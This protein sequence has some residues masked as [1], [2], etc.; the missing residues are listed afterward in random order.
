MAK[1]SINQ[2]QFT[3]D[4]GIMIAQSTV[5]KVARLTGVTLSLASAFYALQTTGDKYV[6]TLR[7]N[8]LRFG[9]FI[10]TI[11]QMEKAQERL[12][13]GQTS[14][15]VDDQLKGLNQ[16]AAVGINVRKDFDFINK[17]AHATGK[18][19]SEFSSAI[20][21]AV[22]GNMQSLV[23]MGL[24]TQRATR[25]FDKYTAN[26]VMRQQA[27]LNFVK[28]HKGLNDLI[29]NDFENIQDQIVRIKATW[30]G[31][32]KGVVGK[33]NDPESLYGMVNKSLKSIAQKFSQSYKDLKQ[34]GKG[35]G[36]VMGWTVRQIGRTIEWLG[37]QG[38][39][40]INFLLGSSETFVERMRTL[41]V[42]LEF[43]RLKVRD[44]FD[45]YGN[46]IK[47]I[48]KWLLIFKGLKTVF[49]ISKAAIASAYAYN[50]ALF[51]RLGFFT[52]IKRVQKSIGGISWWKAF[53]LSV[54]PRWLRRTLTWFSRFFSVT[55]PK[56]LPKTL[57]LFK[58]IGSFIGGGL[59]S[60]AGKLIGKF[61]GAVGIWTT[62]YETLQWI[63]RKVFGI[64]NSFGTMMKNLKTSW[65]SL[66]NNF[67]SFY[68]DFR[69]QW[70]SFSDWW[71]EHVTEPI[72]KRW[73]DAG[74]SDWFTNMKNNFKDLIDTVKGWLEPIFK[75][76]RS[77]MNWFDERV[78]TF[79]S[80]QGQK[81]IQQNNFRNQQAL[82]NINWVN[83]KRKEAVA[84]G[85]DPNR[86]QYTP[87]AQELIEQGKK[88]N[89]KNSRTDGTTPLTP[90]E[91][92]AFVGA[93][94]SQYA[95]TKPLSEGTEK[96]ENP[97]TAVKN[98]TQP[99]YTAQDVFNETDYSSPIT[100]ENG[101]VQIIVQKGEGID[102][103]KLASKVKQIISDLQRETR[104]R[105]GQ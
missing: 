52:R 37:R 75:P 83:A 40:A 32:L 1:T 73:Q 22:Q 61:A 69:Y 64:D 66:K 35:I 56:A 41:V 98:D 100:L 97:I 26:T 50:A 44:F 84:R 34:Y 76:F 53:W 16:L 7:E 101:A 103:Q 58:K 82:N 20:A 17:S 67:F 31:F 29:K 42:W 78:A 49:V 8:S 71:S 93:L 11:Q 91:R 47:S 62:V 43:W 3:Y 51:G 95:S 10:S 85:Y 90:K 59:T 24:M 19:F 105:K 89:A 74:W 13:K 23:D 39:K 18:S 2:A 27:I 94:R 68:D 60:S 4:F 87:R 54:I 70:S 79:K 36:I 5:N 15:S 14:F 80:V 9:G 72:R 33:P 102:E 104:M 28:Q 92:N 77:L 65:I 99:T 55:L 21:N 6:K 45:E 88:I 86:Y 96:V 30:S 46:S 48:I 81:L 57:G 25:M 38:K 12:I 63:D